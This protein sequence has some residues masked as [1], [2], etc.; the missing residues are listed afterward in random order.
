MNAWKMW[1][2]QVSFRSLSSGCQNWFFWRNSIIVTVDSWEETCM[3][4][5]KKDFQPAKQ[6][7]F[8]PFPPFKLSIHNRNTKQAWVLHIMPI[9]IQNSLLIQITSKKGKDFKGKWIAAK[10]TYT[11]SQCLTL[12]L[13]EIMYFHSSWSKAAGSQCFEPCTGHLLWVPSRKHMVWEET[14]T[15]SKKVLVYNQQICK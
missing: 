7:C 8:L 10:N 9:L 2:L 14:K 4:G 12:N 3:S 1:W 13:V 5:T 15:P 6:R 11:Q